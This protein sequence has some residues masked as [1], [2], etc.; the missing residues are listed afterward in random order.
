MSV[1]FTVLAGVL[2]A[3]LFVWIDRRYRRDIQ[4]INRESEI[5]RAAIDAEHAAKC[6]EID[7]KH[8]HRMRVWAQADIDPVFR[9]KLN[10]EVR[11]HGSAAVDSVVLV[12]DKAQN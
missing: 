5:R 4:R 2:W 12:D 11:K 7:R 1:A 8:D 6:A 9:R 10:E 3:L